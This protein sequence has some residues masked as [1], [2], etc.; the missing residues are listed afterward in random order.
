[1]TG[2]KQSHYEVFW[3]TFLHIFL[4]LRL[5]ELIRMWVFTFHEIWKILNTISSNCFVCFLSFH[6]F[7]SLITQIL[8]SWLKLFHSS[9]VFFAFFFKITF[10]HFKF[11]NIYIAIYSIRY[12]SL[13]FHFR[14]NS[15]HLWKFDVVTFSI[16][17]LNF[18]TYVL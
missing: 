3:C 16:L 5:I 18:L 12:L 2:L 13:N 1:M 17:L 11:C 14:H 6:Y 7:R 9:L 8:K 10:F 15:F 4:C